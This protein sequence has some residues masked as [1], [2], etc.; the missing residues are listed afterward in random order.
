MPTNGRG[1]PNAGS[2]GCREADRPQVF[3]SRWPAL[4]LLPRKPVDEQ[5]DGARTPG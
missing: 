4:P 3:W 2:D 1:S 5:K